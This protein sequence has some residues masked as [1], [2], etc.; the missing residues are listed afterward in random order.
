MCSI[1]A[2]PATRDLPYF[3]WEARRRK[4]PDESAAAWVVREGFIERRCALTATTLLAC[5]GEALVGRAERITP[6]G[7]GGG[8][9]GRRAKAGRAVPAHCASLDPPGAPP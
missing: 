3:L 5:D 4:R 7:G 9:E 6:S 2:R 1:G 8:R